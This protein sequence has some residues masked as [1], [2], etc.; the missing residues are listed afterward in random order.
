MHVNQ[1]L[2]EYN[3]HEHKATC[4]K[5]LRRGEAQTHDKCR[6][7]MTGEVFPATVI[8][9][10]TK[11]IVIKRTHRWMAHYT[12]VVTFLMK[13]N[14]D[15]KF[16]GSGAEAE[17]FMYYVTD[18]ITKPALS[19]HVGLS[20]LSYAMTRIENRFRDVQSGDSSNAAILSDS[21]LASAMT[22]AVNSMVG[23]QEISH[24][25]V[26]SYLIGGG[27]HY[28]SHTF[29]SFNW[30][31]IMNHVETYWMGVDALGRENVSLSM[32][33]G[34]L[35]VS[36]HRL[37]YT[38]RPDVPEY[39]ILCLYHFVAWVKKVPLQRKR[40]TGSDGVDR[41]TGGDRFSSKDH[42]QWETHGVRV[43]SQLSVPVLLGP[44]ILQ[45]GSV[46]DDE[47]RA[48]QIL[49]L[50]K[51]WRSAA[52]LKNPDQTWVDALNEMESQFSANHKSLIANLD[53]LAQSKAQ[54][55]R[56]LAAKREKRK[57]RM[58]VGGAPLEDV[59]EPVDEARQML[60]R[61]SSVYN[62]LAGSELLD[63]WTLY[64]EASRQRLR[65]LI[66]PMN[67]R[68]Y[69][70]CYPASFESACAKDLEQLGKT[71]APG[72]L[73]CG[74]LEEPMDLDD[75]IRRVASMR[76]NH[77]ESVTDGAPS[78]ATAESDVQATTFTERPQV[79]IEL[80]HPD[81]NGVPNGVQGPQQY[82]TDVRWAQV[83]DVIREKGL[84]KNPEQLRAFLIV[85]QHLITGGDQLL[86]YIGGMGGT[87]KS[88]VVKSIVTLFERLGKRRR[89]LIGAPTGIAAVLLEV[90]AAT[91]HSLIVTNAKKRDTVSEK[92]GDIWR[93]VSYLIVD[94]ISMVGASFLAQISS[95]I[96]IAKGDDPLS[97]GKLFGGVNVICLGDFCQL[98]PVNQQA[99]FSS[100]LGSNPSFAQVSSNH[101]LDSMAGIY[102][103]RQFRT[104]V[105]LRKN[106]R[107]KDDPT[108]AQFLSNMR[109]KAWSI[110]IERSIWTEK[111]YLDYISQ[112][113]LARV[114]R[115]DPIGLRSFYDAPVVVGHRTLRDALNVKMIQF[116]A[117]RLGVHP[118]LYHL[119]DALS[120]QAP[121]DATQEVLWDLPSGRCGDMLG[122]LPLF[123]GMKVMVMENI[124]ISNGIVNGAEGVV[125]D[126][127]YHVDGGGRRIADAVYIRV[128]KCRVELQ[129]QSDPD[130]VVIA[131]AS[132]S[133]QFNF[134][135]YCP[136]VTAQ[137]F[138]RRQIPIMP[139]YSYTDYKSQGRS[140][141]KCIIDLTTTRGQGV[142]VMLSRVTSLQG[143]LIFRWFPPSQLFQRPSQELRQE[144]RRLDDLS[145][146]TATALG[147]P[148]SALH[149]V[150]GS[151][152]DMSSD[153]EGD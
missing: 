94:E 7:G 97:D 79:L 60:L 80:I 21:H 138:R 4:W 96:K 116:H 68:D 33:T 18:Y 16:I 146:A 73:M 111:M 71:L 100:T 64:T 110:P 8:N 150:Y 69:D 65:E 39:A 63:Q 121:D 122:K 27:D 67:D 133:V 83:Y 23:H 106:Q 130:V 109:L 32:T 10:E 85:A 135:A 90:G 75:D 28:I 52:D 114:A 74:P 128:P 131:A 37:D 147:D 115:T 9:P 136:G 72:T 141:Q 2:V 102:I 98:K 34:R 105:Q 108:Y 61:D 77:I 127:R 59:E 149:A 95:R 81:T 82:R 1:L 55:D 47:R 91:L 92:L 86:M 41:V 36:S 103:W 35:S 142:Y 118:F 76:S 54:R 42:P 120:G 78:V 87:G 145:C 51:A 104:V 125:T 126:I 123:V 17:A 143:L 12:D 14:N 119:A 99:L 58:R 152:E 112:R 129:G 31:A 25:Q 45:K 24:Q 70:L 66:G 38:F 15:V 26:M 22:I 19:M 29:Q 13:C 43:R 101:G 88:H 144:L 49:I 93:P 148:F 117:K 48:M 137:S 50:F 20:A 62:T 30:G 153:T 3:L 40:S 44:S 151:V 132:N 56:N 113:L 46:R 53:A 139:A 11:A 57:D 89:L 140:L 5:Y 107:Q 134:A 124:A 6:M 84:R